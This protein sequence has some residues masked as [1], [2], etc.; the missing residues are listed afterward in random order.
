VY[1]TVTAIMERKDFQCFNTLRRGSFKV[2]ERPFP[3]ILTILI[4]FYTVFL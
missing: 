1:H 2:F 4:N 3:G